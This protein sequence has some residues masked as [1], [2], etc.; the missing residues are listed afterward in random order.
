MNNSLMT[1]EFE[2][3]SFREETIDRKKSS[4]EMMPKGRARSETKERI[5]FEKKVINISPAVSM[6]YDG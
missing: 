6:F 1:C 2:V 5:F 4:V 3:K